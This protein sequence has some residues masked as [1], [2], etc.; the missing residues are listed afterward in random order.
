MQTARW[1]G[2]ALNRQVKS[3]SQL[4]SGSRI[5]SPE[6]D[7]GGLAQSIK[8]SNESLRDSAALTNLKNSLSFL[9]TKDGFLEKVQKA[10]DRMSELAVLALDATKTDQDRQNYDGEFQA[11]NDFLEATAGKSF[12]GKQLFYGNYEVVTGS[13]TWTDAKADAKSRGG[14][15]AAITNPNE[16]SYALGQ[17]GGG[18]GA[19]GNNDLWLG[20]SN[21][22]TSDSEYAW[23]TGE[24]V[25]WTNWVTGHPRTVAGTKYIFGNGEPGDGANIYTW[26]TQFGGTQSAYL[27]EKGL[28]LVVNGDGQTLQV[29]NRGIPSFTD[30]L[31]TASAARTALRSTTR[32]VEDVAGA[33]A[34]VGSVIQRVTAE[35]EGLSIHTENLNASVSR[36]SDTDVASASTEFARNTLLTQAGTAMMA[37]ANVLPQAALRLLG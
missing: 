33:R 4:S 8:L 3:L 9:Q 30:N 34:Q 25:L 36:I 7:A 11:L 29:D 2:E 37:Q 20:G 21:E 6:D 1:L 24:S 32:A 12:N 31:L 23:V 27:L 28:S 15:L 5:T 35:M 17:L 22:T 14:H 18:T 26:G 13:M 16:L 19:L 10:I